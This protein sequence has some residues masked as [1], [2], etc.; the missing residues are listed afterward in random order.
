MIVPSD[1]LCEY[2]DCK[3]RGV[4]GLQGAWLC[5]AHFDKRLSEMRAALHPAILKHYRHHEAG[6]EMTC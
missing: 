3:E 4:G 1:P 2:Q 6:T 5:L